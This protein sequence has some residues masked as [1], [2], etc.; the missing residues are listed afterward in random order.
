MAGGRRLH[1]T[2]AG[3]LLTRTDFRVPSLATVDLAGRAV[4][5]VVSRGKHL[6]TRIEGGITLHTHFRMDGSWHLYRPGE[7]WA[8]AR[9]TRCGVVLSNA[10]R[11]AVGYRLPRRRAGAHG[12]GGQVVGHL[13]PDLLGA[14][15]GRAGRGRRLRRHRT[16][17]SA[18]RCSISAT[19]PGSGTSTRPKPCS[20]TGSGPGRPSRRRVDL[21]PLVA[22]PSACCRQPATGRSRP[23]QDHAARRAALGL[24]AEPAPCRRCGTPVAVA[25]QGDPPRERLTY[26]CPTCQPAPAG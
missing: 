12:R 5:E 7:R 15:L 17:R 14:G 8:A 19:S 13:G 6:L 11:V 22:R 26:W 23:R 2:L 24:R 20:C 4:T 25:P 16:A 3:R 21:A 9:T 18:R 1:G 10:D